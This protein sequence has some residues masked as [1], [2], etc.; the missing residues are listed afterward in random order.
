MKLKKIIYGS[1]LACFIGCSNEGG[2]ID[3]NVYEVTGV[4]QKGPFVRGSHIGIFELNDKLVQ[5]GKSFSSEIENDKG[6][7]S[8]Q[9]SNLESSYILLEADG[10]FWNECTGLN[11]EN[12]LTLKAMAN[13]KNGSNINVN[14]LTHLAIK[15][16]QKLVSEG[17]TFAEA[18]AQAEYEISEAFN[19]KNESA[20]ESLDVF[21]NAQLSAISI[22][23]LSLRSSANITEALSDLSGDL[24]DGRFDNESLKIRLADASAMQYDMY[25]L[26]R[27][28]ME[29]KIQEPLPP[30]EAFLIN[31]WQSVY[32][33]PQ[34]TE[35]NSNELR[36]IHAKGSEYDGKTVI[37]QTTYTPIWNI[38]TQDELNTSS[39]D[40][41]RDGQMKKGDADSTWYTFDGTQWRRS[42][43]SEIQIGEGCTQAR[44]NSEEIITKNGVGYYCEIKGTHIKWRTAIIYRYEKEDFFNKEIKY[45]SVVD[46][47]DEQEYKTVE[48]AGL[49]W[50]AENLN[51]GKSDTST[52]KLYTWSEAMKI[53]CMAGWH[54]PD[55]TEWNLLKEFSVEDLQSS[56]GWQ[57]G[58]N[59]TGFSSVPTLYFNV[60][61][62]PDFDYVAKGIASYISATQ[63]STFDYFV[64]RNSEYFHD[65]VSRT[66]DQSSIRCVKDK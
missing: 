54:I 8:V 4:V 64:I 33:L 16:I 52:A 58:N 37:C 46:E 47:R 6:S 28:Y 1:I 55:S 35:Q 9:T 7:F 3:P 2:V 60:I 34:C 29:S 23:F 65:T 25:A 31:F 36:T 38:A 17:T 57:A 26:S 41:G 62:T 30:F 14:L 13:L 24:E 42:S 19:M 59:K 40:K 63:D 49:T 51:Y 11:S 22:L 15:R 66:Y 43:E 50:M 27:I 61:G 32:G 21:K 48:L 44:A 53:G 56:V 5:T 18:K 10:Y 39:W 45:G 12:Q 20:F